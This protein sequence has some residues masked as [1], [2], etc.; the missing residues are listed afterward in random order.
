MIKINRNKNTDLNILMAVNYK[1]QAN[2]LQQLQKNI[3]FGDI[4]N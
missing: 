2:Y 3:Q 1:K 4:S